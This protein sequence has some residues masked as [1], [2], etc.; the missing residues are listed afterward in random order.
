M[1]EIDFCSRENHSQIVKIFCYSR[2]APNHLE[3]FLG[4]STPPPPQLRACH[5]L[6]SSSA[7]LPAR[8]RGDKVGLREWRELIRGKIFSSAAEQKQSR[9][10]KV[11]FS[12]QKSIRGMRSP[13]ENEA[14][15]RFQQGKAARDL[16]YFI[17]AAQRLE[18]FSSGK[19]FQQV[20]ELILS[21]WLFMGRGS[22]RESSWLCNNCSEL[23]WLLGKG[24][25]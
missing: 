14:L 4:V 6:G 2:D 15:G 24:N 22:G 9:E 20:F 1:K 13:D 19:C 8:G 25:P 5:A 16:F 7:P 18:R 17:S 10:L 3:G 12:H 21:L 11:L 23:C